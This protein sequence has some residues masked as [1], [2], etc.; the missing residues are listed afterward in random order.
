MPLFHKQLKDRLIERGW[1]REEAERTH[2]L[3]NDPDRQA[4]HQPVR[5]Q[6][7]LIV[8]WMVLTVLTIGNFMISLVL[9]PIIAILNMYFMTS[10]SNKFALQIQSGGHESPFLISAVYVVMFIIPYVVTVVRSEL[11]KRRER[12]YPLSSGLQQE[13]RG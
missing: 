2:N 1:S 12:M 3:I 10:V 11:K 5:M 7:N 6:M 9:I 13:Q 4:K 8:Y